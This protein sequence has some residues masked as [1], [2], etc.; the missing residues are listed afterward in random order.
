MS[1]ILVEVRVPSAD[2]RTDVFIPYECRLRDVTELIKK[3]FADDPDSPFTP[4]EDTM[5]C[6]GTS[7]TVLDTSRSAEELGLRNG[8]KLLLL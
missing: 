8:A 5:L 4:S 3:V 2:L 1:R 7:G 6:D